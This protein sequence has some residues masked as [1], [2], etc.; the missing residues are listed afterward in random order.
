MRRHATTCSGAYSPAQPGEMRAS[1]ATHTISVNTSACPAVRAAAEVHEVVVVGHAIAARVLR[2]RRHDDA[3]AQRQAAQRERREH[4]RHRLG[5]AAGA[6]RI[7]G[8]HA[9]DEALV[10]QA[11]VLVRNALAARQQ[12][13]GELLRLERRVALDVLEPLGR[14]ARGV[15]DLQH[16]HARGRPRRPRAPPE[17]RL[18]RRVRAQARWRPRARAWCRTPRK[19]APCARHR[20]RG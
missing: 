19:N 9:G 4:R 7:P 13:V 14:I 10:A 3:I 12:A 5:L 17:G 8:L 2:H 15:L 18:R 6:S 1:G 11:Q 20:R 16:F